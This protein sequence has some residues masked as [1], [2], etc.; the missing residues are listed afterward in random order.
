MPSIV[1]AN[2]FG[3]AAIVI[4]PIALWRILYHRQF[5]PLF[6]AILEESDISNSLVMPSLLFSPF[7]FSPLKLVDYHLGC[8]RLA[9][10]HVSFFKVATLFL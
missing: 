6:L 7:C 2:P 8:D 4:G 10:L 5:D 3:G 1:E 9:W